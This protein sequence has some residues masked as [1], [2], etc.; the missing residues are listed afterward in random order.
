MIALPRKN[1]S[2]NYQ[3]RNGVYI[4]QFYIYNYDLLQMTDC[5]LTIFADKVKFTANPLKKK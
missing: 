2:P 5:Q 1:P 3:A 4:I